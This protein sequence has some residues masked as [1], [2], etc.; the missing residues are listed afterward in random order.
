MIGAPVFVATLLAIS[1]VSHRLLPDHKV[2]SESQER[3]QYLFERVVA[4]DSG[5][6]GKTVS[7]NALRRLESMF[8]AELVRGDKVFS[9]VDPDFILQ[10][11]DVLVFSGDPRYEHILSEFNGLSGREH[12]SR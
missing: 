6:V 9:P 11:R 12:Q 1:L 3:R 4:A 5:M 7:E 2:V 8:L 10:A